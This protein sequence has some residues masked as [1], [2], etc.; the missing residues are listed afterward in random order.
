MYMEVVNS[1]LI[2]VTMTQ[3]TININSRMFWYLLE[4][5]NFGRTAG[6]EKTVFF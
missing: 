4:S 5:P 2:N 1:Y 3:L 6:S